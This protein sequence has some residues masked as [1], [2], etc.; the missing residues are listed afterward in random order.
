MV[1]VLTSDGRSV[2]SARPGVMLPPMQ[3]DPAPEW[4]VRVRRVG[5]TEWVADKSWTGEDV[6]T[7]VDPFDDAEEPQLG[8]FEILVTGPLGSDARCV[9][10]VAEGL[11]ASFDTLIRIQVPGGLTPCRGEIA[12]WRSLGFAGRPACIWTS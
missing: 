3:S 9:V 2:H 10:F 4:N 6:E 11:D 5:D 7:C 1:G 8:L 12:D